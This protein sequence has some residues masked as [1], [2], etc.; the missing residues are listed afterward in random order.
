MPILE[1]M[2]CGLPVIA[3]FWSAQQLFMN[4][5]NSYPLQVESLIPAEAKC[6]YYKGFK[7]ANPDIWHLKK[8]LRNVYENPDEAKKKGTQAVTDVQKRRAGPAS[9]CA[10]RANT[11]ES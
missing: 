9:T 6:P 2:A 11:I 7:W 5:A 10:L 1:A 8:L 4:D 3:P